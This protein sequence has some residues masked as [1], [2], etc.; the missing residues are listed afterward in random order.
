VDF[1]VYHYLPGWRK[2]TI[3]TVR[4]SASGPRYELRTTWMLSKLLN[5]QQRIPRFQ[6]F[7]LWPYTRQRGWDSRLYLYI[8]KWMNY[9]LQTIWALTGINRRSGLSTLPASIQQPWGRGQ[10]WSSKRSSLQNWTNHLTRLIARENFIIELLVIISKT[11]S[12]F[13]EENV[14]NINIFTLYVLYENFLDLLIYL[15]IS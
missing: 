7:F 5:T 9:L 4:I 2:I 11:I 12:T 13:Y 14:N 1:K 15:N 8:H 3:T 10:R 6:Y